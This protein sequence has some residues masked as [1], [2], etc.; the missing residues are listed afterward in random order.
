M[1][2][3]PAGLS[4][5]ALFLYDYYCSASTQDT[6]LIRESIEMSKAPASND[7]G[8]LKY[9]SCPLTSNNLS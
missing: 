6:P 7:I 3:I 9:D 8:R 4:F 5:T 1:A 2:R